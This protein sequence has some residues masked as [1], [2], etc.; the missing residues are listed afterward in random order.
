MNELEAVE[1]LAYRDLVSHAPGGAVC[2]LRGGL[3]LTI[4]LLPALEVNRVVRVTADLDLDAVASFFGITP[5]MVSA[6]AGLAALESSLEARGYTRR[7]AWMKF[8]RGAEPA[9]AAHTGLTVDETDDPGAFGRPAAA[10]FTGDAA[11]HRLFG[12]VV[13]LR[14]WHCFVARA[15]SEEAA[16]G[17]L[18]VDGDVGWL[19]VGATRAEFR[20]QGAQNAIMAARIETGRS[21]GVRRFVTE[22]GERLPGRE[23]GSYR[24]IL[25][26]GFREAYVRPNWASG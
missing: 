4:A 13:G 15:G 10:A 26:A 24:N 19:G 8:D 17:A 22:T 3:C 5:H 7:Y 9:P 11:N 6:P 16:S 14:G 18:F 23:S 25:R 20:R 21:L 1:A 2:E 12:G